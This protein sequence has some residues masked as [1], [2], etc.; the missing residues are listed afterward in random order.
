MTTLS[1][2]FPQSFT[3]QIKL[4]QEQ[5]EFAGNAVIKAKAGTDSLEFPEASYTNELAWAMI[6]EM[7]DK[8]SDRDVSR[9]I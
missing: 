6:V 7:S 1:P 4:S 8:C 3:H 5:K 9:L 2:H